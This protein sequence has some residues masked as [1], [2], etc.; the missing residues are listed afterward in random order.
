MSASP[1]FGFTIEY[2]DDIE[3]AKH[4][5]TDVLGLEMLRYAPTF[6]QFDHFAIASDEALGGTREPEQYWL[7]NDAEAAFS[8][9]SKKAEISL[10]LKQMPFGKVFAIKDPSGHPRFLIELAQNRPSQPVK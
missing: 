10:P 6:I 8:E 9:L 5:Y 4:F 3:K 2:V 1:K 7:V